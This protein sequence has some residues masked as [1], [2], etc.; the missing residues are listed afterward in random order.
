MFYVQQK[1]TLPTPEQ[2]LPGRTEKM[3]VTHKHMVLGT[4]LTEP[5]PAGYEKI[6]FGLGCFWGLNVVFGNSKAYT[7]RQWAT[8]QV[9]R[10]IQLM[11]R[12]VVG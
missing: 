1:V 4:T 2:A 3:P 12:F 11:K 7:P 6:V 10:P 5:F 9:I 8:Q